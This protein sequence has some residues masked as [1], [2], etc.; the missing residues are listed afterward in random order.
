[1]R[2]SKGRFVDADPVGE[3]GR[4]RPGTTPWN[5]SLKGWDAGGRS[6][7]TR[8]KKGNTPP[9][10]KPEGTVSRIASLKKNGTREIAYYINIDWR[11]NRKAHNNY[12]WYLWE[13]ENQQDRP[14]GHV[15]ITKNG[16]PDDIR[17]ENLQ[18]ISRAELIKL[19]NPKGQY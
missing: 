15:L 14:K 8:F 3:P 5:K 17:I 7:Q 2:D 6:H 19:N 11:G 1:M 13:V 16:N 10:Q 12:R 9:Q 18:L 4:F